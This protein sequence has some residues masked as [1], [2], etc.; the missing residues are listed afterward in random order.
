MNSERH[1][2]YFTI[3]NTQPHLFDAFQSDLSWSW[4]R[5]FYAISINIE[6]KTCCTIHYHYIVALFVVVHVSWHSQ[7]NGNGWRDPNDK[8][9]KVSGELKQTN[10]GDRKQTL[11]E[12]ITNVPLTNLT[13][14][15]NDVE[16]LLLLWR[17]R[18]Q[19]FYF[20]IGS[21]SWRIGSNASEER[22]KFPFSHLWRAFFPI[23]LLS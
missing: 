7:W 5:T 16:R 17:W 13:C 21:I 15:S 8:M 22:V 14:L 18:V 4:F 10:H 3:S 20:S 12:M 9:F 23:Y 6:L 2:Q 11:N 1:V 19:C